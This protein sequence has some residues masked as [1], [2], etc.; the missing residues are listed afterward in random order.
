MSNDFLVLVS[1]LNR[2]ITSR[3]CA[4]YALSI[5]YGDSEN[6]ISQ[7]DKE[8][9]RKDIRKP[10]FNSIIKDL[11]ELKRSLYHQFI[12]A[13]RTAPRQFFTLELST[14]NLFHI[15]ILITLQR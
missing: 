8:E 15:G 12:F 13:R 7:R 1:S 14:Y 6:L 4:S 10:N 2:V 5:T 11:K 3:K 9:Q